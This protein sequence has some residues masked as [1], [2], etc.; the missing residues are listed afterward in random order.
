M[1][2]PELC[3]ACG[4]KYGHMADC[5]AKR[6]HA[7][8]DRILQRMKPPFSTCDEISTVLNHCEVVLRTVAGDLNC[9]KPNSTS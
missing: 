4:M 9:P 3:P 2:E 6:L 8:L 1:P 7:Q 5:E